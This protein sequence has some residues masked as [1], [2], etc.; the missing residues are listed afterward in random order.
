MGLT[1]GL[2]PYSWSEYEKKGDMVTAM[3]MAFTDL[4][5]ILFSKLFFEK[6]MDI[7]ENDKT[8]LGKYIKLVEVQGV[9]SEDMLSLLK[10]FRDV[11]NKVSHERGYIE[12]M[13]R[14][15]NESRRVKKLLKH[16]RHFIRQA[17]IKTDMEREYIFSEQ[18]RRNKRL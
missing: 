5:L 4:E 18:V 14:D 6:K 8:T 10:E 12:L 13:Y 11:R 7:N 3:T 17:R 2:R 15:A 9:F 1:R 16:I